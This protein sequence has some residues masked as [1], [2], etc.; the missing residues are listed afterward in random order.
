[1]TEEELYKFVGQRL[2]ELRKERNI[3]NYENLAYEL[4]IA[5]SQYWKY[6]NGSNMKLSTLLKITNYYDIT[7]EEFFNH[8]SSHQVS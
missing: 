8:A 5:R 2:R 7:I 1:M 3:S 6:E 4:G